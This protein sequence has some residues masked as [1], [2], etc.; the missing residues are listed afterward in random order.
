MCSGLQQFFLKYV[1]KCIRCRLSRTERAFKKGRKLLDQE[2][3]IVSIIKSRRFIAEALKVL[4]T[5]QQWEELIERSRFVA[6][7]PNKETVPKDGSKEFHPI[8]NHGAN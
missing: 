4:L 1:P 7:D 6:I 2:T 3:N 8:V 5:K